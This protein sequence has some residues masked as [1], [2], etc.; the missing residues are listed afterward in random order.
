M[1]V[2]TMNMDL[3]GTKGTKWFVHINRISTTWT[4]FI[5]DKTLEDIVRRIETLLNTIDEISKYGYDNNRPEKLNQIE[6]RSKD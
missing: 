2:R 1:T 4:F 3:M 6:K 5:H